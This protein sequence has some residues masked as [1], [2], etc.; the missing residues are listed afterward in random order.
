MLAHRQLCL[1]NSVATL[2]DINNVTGVNDRT[3][4]MVLLC[5]L[6]STQQT[7][8]MGNDISINLYLRN[9]LLHGHDEVVEELCLE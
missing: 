1:D 3:H 6:G 2:L 8:Q 7:V 4:I 5:C 9:K